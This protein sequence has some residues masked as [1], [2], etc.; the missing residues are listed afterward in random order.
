MV[1]DLIGMT[2]VIFVHREFVFP[3][4]SPTLANFNIRK[5]LCTDINLFS[6]VK[7]N[8]GFNTFLPDIFDRYGLQLTYQC[9]RLNC[10]SFGRHIG[11]MNLYN[12]RISV[13]VRYNRRRNIKI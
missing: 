5:S 9:I 3:Q 13:T 1:S 4:H 10:H 11:H 8:G 6:Y 7:V 12:T 2:Y